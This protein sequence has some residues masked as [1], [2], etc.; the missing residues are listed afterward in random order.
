[1]IGYG[2]DGAS[3]GAEAVHGEAIGDLAVGVVQS[4]LKSGPVGIAG[5]ADKVNRSG[6]GGVEGGEF[7]RS[8]AADGG[9]QGR[10][11]LGE[12][13]KNNQASGESVNRDVI[14]GLEGLEE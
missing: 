12:L 10:S 13:V 5:H 11:V 9:D 7:L 8:E 2:L 6:G 4:I 14:L 3:G 1:M